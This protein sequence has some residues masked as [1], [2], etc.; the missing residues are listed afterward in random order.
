[1][2]FTRKLIIHYH[3]FK[4]AGTSIDVNLRRTFGERFL[5]LELGGPADLF[6]AEKLVQKL[7]ENPR[8]CAVSSHTIVLPLPHRQDW[9]VLPIIFLRHPLDR[10][11]SMYRYEREQDSESP[12]AALAKKYD[13]PDYVV[14]RL[15]DPRDVVLR[16]WQ[17]CWLAMNSVDINS[18]TKDDERLFELASRVIEELPFVGVVERF[19][20]SLLVLNQICS[21]RALG[22]GFKVG[23]HNRSTGATGSVNQ[24]SG[25][26][27]DMLDA[28][29]YEELRLANS[30]D[31]RLHKLA[32]EIIEG[33]YSD[34]NC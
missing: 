27:Q 32:L 10:I 30:M 24:K 1:M 29:I 2:Q 14:S 16:N 4:N 5:E 33:R 22:I 15:S 19:V 18:F 7:E 11:L 31:I 17:T 6:T 34:L 25:G 26:I 23:H 3:L 8:V 21:D 12:G 13:F 9:S 20:K 28:D